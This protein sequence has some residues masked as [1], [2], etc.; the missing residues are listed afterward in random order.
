M[1]RFVLGQH[2]L[3]YRPNESEEI[4]MK[5]FTREE[6]EALNMDEKQ[7]EA[8]LKQQGTTE[9][10]MKAIA[11]SE[12]KE[13]QEKQVT[14]VNN[15][16]NFPQQYDESNIT[17]IADIKN[18]TAGSIVKLPGFDDEHPFI[19]KLKRPSLLL[20]VK[21][22][23]IPNSLINQATQLFQRGAGSLGKDNTISDMY[24][25]MET[26]CEAALIK[27]T[28]KEIKDAG[29]NLTDEQMMAIFSYTQQGVKALEQFR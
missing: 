2:I 23:K 28:Y 15:I 25:I 22:G 26:V 18:Y 14:V 8:I 13:E 29:L 3:Y 21:T 9:V 7:I 19:A 6:L 24:D 1:I 5:V 17:T 12:E 16:T 4:K 20:M 11:E 10:A 27:P